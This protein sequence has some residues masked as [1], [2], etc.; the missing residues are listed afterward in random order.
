MAVDNWW[1]ADRENYPGWYDGGGTPVGNPVDGTPPAQTPRNGPPYTTAN[2]PPPNTD[3][4]T[5]WVLN[6]TTGEFELRPRN[7][8][9]PP[10]GNTTTTNT[11]PPPGNTTTTTNTNGGFDMDFGELPDVNWSVFN[12]RQFTYDPFP[13]VSPFEFKEFK[14]PTLEQA[15]QNPGYQFAKK[16]MLGT[17]QNSYAGRGLARTPNAYNAFMQ[18]VNNLAEQNYGN[19]FNRERDVFGTNE[20][21]RFTAYQENTGNLF[22]TWKTNKDLALDIF[23]RDY[24]GDYDKFSFTRDAEKFDANTAL[25][26]WLAKV[27]SATT[28]A[29]P[30]G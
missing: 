21:N 15:E 14:A 1:D 3:P 23:D 8:T 9:P 29:R 4:E 10:P 26:K 2:P 20:G 7:Q 28:L 16:E 6:P 25:Q 27:N 22:N 17:L 5:E 24:K 12:P 18:N 13:G 11:P 19:V 30:V